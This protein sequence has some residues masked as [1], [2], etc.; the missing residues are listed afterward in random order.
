MPF[1]GS[2]GF[3]RTQD[4]TDDAAANIKIRAD[5][6]DN[7]DD[8]IAQGLS[9]VICKDGQTT[10]TAD[11]PWNGKKI[12]NLAN[13]LS[14]QDAATKKY[15]DDADVLANTKYIASVKQTLYTSNGAWTKAATLICA[16]WEVQGSAGGGGGA[17][18]TTAGLHASAGGGGGAGA[19]ASK[20]W[21]AADLPASATVVV[22]QPGSGG[23]GGAAGGDGT[24]STFA[25]TVMQATGGSGGGATGQAT[26]TTPAPGGA[27]G[28]VSGFGYSPVGAPGSMGIARPFSIANSWAGGGGSSPNG[29]GGRENLS[30]F[31]NGVAG[32]G[33]GA[34][35]A[36]AANGDGQAGRVGGAGTPAFWRVTEFHRAA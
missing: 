17:V 22:G 6:H 28:T 2:G 24:L 9:S 14:P 19:N 21:L 15:V 7:N 36:G 29:G 35:G 27:G 12:T 20:L 4:W 33:Y 18:G 32:S 23:G 34:G 3:V 31:V 25:T 8:D 11:I 26:V 5:L 16:I 13:P 1:N 30:V 10:I